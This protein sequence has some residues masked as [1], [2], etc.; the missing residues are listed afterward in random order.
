MVMKTRRIVMM[1]ALAVMVVLFMLV[2]MQRTGLSAGPDLHAIE[3]KGGKS[4]EGI[5]MELH[6]GTYLLRTEG[7][8]LILPAHEIRKVDGKAPAKLDLPV[9]DR[10]PRLQ[11]TY[12]DVSADGRITLHSTHS[13]ENRGS[14]IIKLIKW[15]LAKHE[16]GH[17]E[18]YK[19]V[20]AFGNELPVEVKDAKSSDR[21]RVTV[22]LAR[23]NLPGET[24]QLTTIYEEKEG[25]RKQDDMWVYRIDGDYPDDRLVTR[26]VR[27]PA[28]AEIVSVS[29]E[30]LHQVTSGDRP[31]VVWRRY[32]MK[33]ERIPWLIRYKL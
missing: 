27:L 24:L 1:S 18:T 8:S 10:V 9:S 33:G 7:E 15:G 6:A 2:V 21:K 14:K 19:V 31:L 32:F 12:E 5:L 29:P 16:L 3:L 30:P 20:D 23:P 17:L 13:Y 11:E 4:A 22:H 25:V 26:S 28:G